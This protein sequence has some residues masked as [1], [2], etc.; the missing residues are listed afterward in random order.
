MRAKLWVVAIAASLGLSAAGAGAADRP[1]EVASG[2]QLADSLCSSCHAVGARGGGTDMAP[3]LP[4]I[5]AARDDESLRLFL[6]APHGAM[7]PL[8]LTRQQIADL[9]AYIGSLRP[10]SAPKQGPAGSS[11]SGR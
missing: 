9:V 10:A 1:A 8:S 7:P 3:T 6:A 4:A 2:Q 11:G 5:A